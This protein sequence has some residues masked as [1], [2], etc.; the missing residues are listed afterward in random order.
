MSVS[1]CV[2]VCLVSLS[3]ESFGIVL[4]DPCLNLGFVFSQLGCKLTSL[5]SPPALCSLLRLQVYAE[6]YTLIHG[7]AAS[8]FINLAFVFLSNSGDGSY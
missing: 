2:Y 5:N 3:K 4:S 6:I 1:L 8:T 7:C